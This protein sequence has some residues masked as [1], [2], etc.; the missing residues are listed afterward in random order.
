MHKTF[1]RHIIVIDDDF[2]FR[3]QT[4]ATIQ[5]IEYSPATN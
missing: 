2:D 4:S 1:E 5:Y 3:N